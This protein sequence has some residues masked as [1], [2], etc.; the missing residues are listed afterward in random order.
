MHVGARATDVRKIWE[1]QQYCLQ[2]KWK[3]IEIA[4]NLI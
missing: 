1:L 3:T 2:I 4:L